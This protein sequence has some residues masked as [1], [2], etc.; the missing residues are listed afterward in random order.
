[1]YNDGEGDKYNEDMNCRLVLSKEQ[2]IC[3]EYDYD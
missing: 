2:V 1:M 3:S